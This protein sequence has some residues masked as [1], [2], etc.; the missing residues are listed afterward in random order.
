MEHAAPPGSDPAGAGLSASATAEGARR[1]ARTT[2]LIVNWNGWHHLG[3][4]I[5][6]ILASDYRDL[7]LLVIDNASADQSA[8]RLEAAYPQVGLVRNSRNVGHTRAVNQGLRLIRS[9]RVLVLDSDTECAPDAIG[10]LARFLDE[11]PDVDMVVPRT[12]NPDG[13]IQETA[14]NFPTVINGLFSRQGVLTRLFPGNPF[15]RRYLQREFRD[16][17]LPFRAESVASSCMY[18]R[19]SLVDRLGEWDEG[20]YGYF[21]DTDWCYRLSR[22]GVQVYCVPAARIVHHE[23]NSS[24]RKRGASRIW[25]FHR[26]ALRFYRKNHTFGWMDPRAILAAAA[27]SSRALVMIA[28]DALKRADAG[29]AQPGR[30]A[31]SEAA[32]ALAGR[33]GQ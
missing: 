4:C 21:V 9:E 28:L 13:T 32:K 17:A 8:E 3:P 5:D 12:F 10:I 31:G 33:S 23:Q 27:L 30:A 26:S 20:Y 24:K 6:S 22:H 7:D 14:R 11:H 15:S 25:M 2:V 16:A 19:K 29:P 1:A 18:F